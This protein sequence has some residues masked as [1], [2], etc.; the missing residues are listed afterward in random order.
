M[1]KRVFVCA[2]VLLLL[3]VSASHA[4]EKRV[5]RLGLLSKLNST[6]EQFTE[7]WRRTFAP[8]NQV[9]DIV[10]KFYDTLTAMQ[11]ALN[12][13]EIHEM[14]LPDFAA[15]YLMRN[16][17]G[18]EAMLVLRSGGTGLAFGFREDSA[19]LRDR[20]NGAVR[21]LRDNW[22][23]SA[24]EG[25]YIA[26]PGNS[27]P[28]PVSFAHFDGAETV[29]VAVTGDLPPIDYIA[30]DGTPAG[31]NTAVLAEIGNLLRVNIELVDVDAGA[32]TAA[33][34]SGRAD[35]VFWYEVDLSGTF[36]PDV[37]SGVIL[38]EPYYGW[39]RFIHLRKAVEKAKA[40]GTWDIKRS[41]LDLFD[42]R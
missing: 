32:R 2:L 23:L 19:G 1:K 15:D 20:F 33:L 4:L 16:N 31:F 27:E 7:K 41:I 11:M 5:I 24:L 17:S 9:L 22:K 39:S 29:K 42:W 18:Y 37:P 36:Q 3:S 14:V 13:R 30:P 10:V 21:T 6:E 40:S 35:V 28:S 38:S 12:A 25:I 34:A 26:S 8:T